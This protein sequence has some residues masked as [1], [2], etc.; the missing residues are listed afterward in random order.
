MNLAA[1]YESLSELEKYYW[2]KLAD[3][4][5]LVSPQKP[6]KGIHALILRARKASNDSQAPL[7]GELETM[8]QAAKERTLRRV[9]LLS[10]CQRSYP[11]GNEEAR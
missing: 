6:E 5:Q 4:F 8:F 1:F 2:H 7:D 9:E 10:H 11:S 3:L